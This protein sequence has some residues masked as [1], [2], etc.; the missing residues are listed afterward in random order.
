MKMKNNERMI[1]INKYRATKSG[2]SWRKRQHGEN[3]MAMAAY[4]KRQ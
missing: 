3:K 1:S 4:V 2:V